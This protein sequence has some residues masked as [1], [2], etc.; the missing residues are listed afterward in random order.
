MKT[1][2]LTIRIEWEGG[3]TI[4]AGKF[5]RF[6]EAWDAMSDLADGVS[7]IRLVDER[8]VTRSMLA[9]WDWYWK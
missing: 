1:I 4:E 7:I 6:S 5:S 9:G 2:T 3:E 8:G